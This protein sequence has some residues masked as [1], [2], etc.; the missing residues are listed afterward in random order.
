[1][2]RHLLT[3]A[4]LALGVATSAAADPCTAVPETGP[5]PAHLTPGKRFGGP[6]AYVGDGDSFCV[7]TGATNA[8]WVEVR[9]A[10]FNAPELSDPGGA[11]ARDALEQLVRYK[12][13][14]CVAGNRTHDRIAARC[15]VAGQS[16]ADLLRAAGV[17]EGGNGRRPAAAPPRRTPLAAPDQGAFRNCAAARAAGAAPLYRGQPGYGAHMDGDGDGVACEPYRGR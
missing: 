4:L 17:R 1:M 15:T 14:S 6:V 10:D 8:S 9:I 11:A 3:A 16:V 7:A 5:T 13:A 2:T 12:R